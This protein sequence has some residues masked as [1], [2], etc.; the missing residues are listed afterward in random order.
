MGWISIF[1]NDQNP[2]S[3]SKKRA[4]WGTGPSSLGRQPGISGITRLATR[5]TS[6]AFSGSLSITPFWINMAGN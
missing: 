1:N 3:R 4:L 2:G 6:Q 5:L